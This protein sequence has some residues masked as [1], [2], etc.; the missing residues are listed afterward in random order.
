MKRSDNNKLNTQLN[1]FITLKFTPKENA[2]G[3]HELQL[4]LL[5]RGDTKSGKYFHVKWG[6]KKHR[7]L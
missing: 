1:Y 3:R 7:A 4:F 2:P 5:Y 6:I